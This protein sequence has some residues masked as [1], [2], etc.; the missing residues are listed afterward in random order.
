[1]K[2]YLTF[3][4]TALKSLKAIDS[5][6]KKRIMGKIELLSENPLEISNV[7]KLVDYDVS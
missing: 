2:Y 5:Q 1:M 7:K 6:N 3:T 4:A